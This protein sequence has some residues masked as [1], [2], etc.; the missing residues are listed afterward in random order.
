MKSALDA[1][2]LP[3][4]MTNL[5]E[6]AKKH[7]YISAIAILVVSFGG[8]RYYQSTHATAQIK[9]VTGT[10]QK[11]TLIKTIDGSGQVSELGKLD[12]KPTGS[13]A[14]ISLPLKQ[15]S[16]VRSGQVVA[17][18]DQRSNYVSLVQARASVANAEANYAK[19]VAGATS[20]DEHL[21]QLAVDSAV[22]SLE[23]SKN[24]YK[25]VELQQQLAVKNAR[26][27]LFNSTPAAIPASNNLSTATVA[28][29]GSY[30]GTQDGQYAISIY[31]GGD[32][33]HYAV[34]G[35]N[36]YDAAI[37]PGLAQPLG[38]DGLS[39]TFSTTGTIVPG[40]TWTVSIPNTQASN[41]LSNSN[42]YQSALVAQ[43]SALSSAQA[44]VNSALNSVESAKAQLEIKQ[45][46]ALPEDVR[47][48]KAQ[49][50]TAQAQLYAAEANYN[51]NI[52]KA[53]FD[54]QIASINSQIGEQVSSATAVA[55]IITNQ[56]IASVSLNEVDVAKIKAGDKVN[57]TFD[58]IDGLS[59]TGQIALID[60]L[61]TVT[62]GV[63]NY[64][65]KI[66][67]D[68]QDERVKPGM[69]ANASIILDVKPDVLA[70]PASAVKTDNSGSYVQQL[71][72][73][74]KPQNIPVTIGF[75]TDTQVEIV[76]GLKE[77]D[78][79][80]TQTI[81][82]GATAPAAASRTAANPFSAIG[83][84]GGNRGGGGGAGAGR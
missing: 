39:I 57:L 46:A 50:Q 16:P 64:A 78:T 48:A 82:V 26:T 13:G 20:S 66:S 77:G 14:V 47:I 73:T 83:G 84:G 80:I 41:Y 36:Y 42:A 33:T 30:L 37:T 15:G 60:T 31:S 45:A 71:D 4:Y 53:P 24:S 2:C 29:S 67:F 52:L 81:K 38:K 44:S 63:V 68:T 5:I 58:A 74:G 21:S 56:K 43:S 65:I 17:V 1:L 72:A 49:I 7:P 19:V 51:G 40:S 55:T 70:V 9:Y 6:T 69:S 75:A 23:N 76:S 35:I 34:G 79:I 11:A 12:L 27:N 25:Q 10:V 54:G 61:G 28:V 62:Q 32:G 59:I 8:Y 18:I 3:Y 22:T